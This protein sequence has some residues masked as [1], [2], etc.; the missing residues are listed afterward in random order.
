MTVRALLAAAAAAGLWLAAMVGMYW[1]FDIL[2]LA[3]VFA[4]AIYY[5]LLSGRGPQASSGRVRDGSG[6]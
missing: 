4:L 1:L 6:R 2:P 5:A 3:L